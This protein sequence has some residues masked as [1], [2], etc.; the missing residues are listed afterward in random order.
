MPIRM[1]E[2]NSDYEPERNKPTGNVLSRLK[3]KHKYEREYIQP[4][5]GDLFPLYRHH[6]IIFISA[7][8]LGRGYG[9]YAENRD[10]LYDKVGQL[11]TQI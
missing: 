6:C 8:Y 5:L 7:K 2:Y 11:L 9:V 4:V 10:E 3:A 1:P